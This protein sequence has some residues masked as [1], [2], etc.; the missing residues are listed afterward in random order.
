MIFH[1]LYHEWV[2]KKIKNW[3]KGLAFSLKIRY[4]V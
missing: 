2:D 1:N 4:N 3:K